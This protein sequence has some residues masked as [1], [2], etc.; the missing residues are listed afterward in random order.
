VAQLSAAKFEALPGRGAKALVE[1]ESVVFGGPRM[2]TKA[3]VTVP[4]EAEKLTTAWASDGKTVLLLRGFGTRFRR[5]IGMRLWLCCIGE[6]IGTWDSRIVTVSRLS[7]RARSDNR[8]TVQS[9]EHSAIYRITNIPLKSP[10]SPEVLGA[11]EEPVSGQ[12]RRY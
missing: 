9:R 6:L 3:K 4:P 1:G 10:K 8:P 2:L 7:R 5:P 11:R 12:F